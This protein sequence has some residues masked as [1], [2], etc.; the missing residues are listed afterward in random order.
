M[1]YSTQIKPLGY[2]KS[3]TAELVNRVNEER[4]PIIIT[5]KGVARAVLVDIHSYE[6]SLDTLASLQILAI[7]EKEIKAGK[8]HSVADVIDKLRDRISCGLG[9]AVVD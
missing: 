1:R 7:G 9:T 8:T 5:K 3:H 2:L 4:E 6:Q